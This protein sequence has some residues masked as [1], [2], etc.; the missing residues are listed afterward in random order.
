MGENI[1]SEAPKKVV[2][3]FLPCR[4]LARE[5]TELRF[6]GALICAFGNGSRLNAREQWSVI[7][8]E[9][10]ECGRLRRPG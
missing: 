6:K 7:S 3:Y 1:P 2:I 8:G 10:V 9:P 4:G 5:D